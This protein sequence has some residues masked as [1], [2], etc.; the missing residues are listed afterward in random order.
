M[1][2]LICQIVTEESSIALKIS[3]VDLSISLLIG[4]YLKGQKEFL[5]RLQDDKKNVF[6]IQLKEIMDSNFDFVLRKTA[7]EQD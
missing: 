7:Q 3:A 5:E 4:G 6:L 2:E 1:V